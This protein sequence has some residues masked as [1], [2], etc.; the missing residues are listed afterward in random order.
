MHTPVEDPARAVPTEMEGVVKSPAPEHVIPAKRLVI[1]T[2]GARRRF[3]AGFSTAGVHTP[4]GALLQIAA[5]VPV[6]LLR[7]GWGG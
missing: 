5:A 3:R 4:I 6:Q 1:T 7:G 2:V